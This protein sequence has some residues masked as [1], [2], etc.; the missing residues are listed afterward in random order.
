MRQTGYLLTLT[1]LLLAG[2]C[3]K[4]E[5]PLSGTDADKEVV[6]F[7][8]G[9]ASEGVS[10]R[11][12]IP[13]MSEGGRFV[14]RMYYQGNPNTPDFDSHYTAWLKVNNKQGNSVYWNKEYTATNELD[15]LGFANNADAIFYWQNR[16][17]HIFVALADNHKLTSNDGTASGT[18][19]LDEQAETEQE[20][21]VH[22]YDLRRPEESTEMTDLPDPIRAIT[23]MAPGGSTQE[24]NRVELVFRHCFA[25]VEVNLRAAINGGADDL[26]ASWIEKVE[27]LGVSEEGYVPYALNGENDVDAPSFKAV[28]LANYNSTQLSRNEFGTSLALYPQSEAT[29]GYMKSFRA[30]AFGQLKAIRITWQ[31]FD[32]NESEEPVAGITHCI[33]RKI[34]ESELQTL[35]SGTRY[36]Y[37]IELRRGTL[38]VIQAE[39][40]PWEVGPTYG[41]AGDIDGTIKEEGN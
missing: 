40:L 4:E 16:K 28:N 35:L 34:T 9:T 15:A 31:E 19:H 38:A 29:T 8:A 39:V 27:L 17:E 33:T 25:Q 22:S 13:Y 3:N 1:L 18:L 14:C 20:D 7:C 30:I 10:T 6:L 26:E 32:T 11:A 21:G 36:I 23:T 12:T 2:A 37:N 41:E 5:A 24:A